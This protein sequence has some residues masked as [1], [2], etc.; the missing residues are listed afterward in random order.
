MYFLLLCSNFNS[1]TSIR[2]VSEFKFP[3]VNCTKCHD[4]ES[5]DLVQILLCNIRKLFAFYTL[6]Y[7]A[8]KGEGRKKKKKFKKKRQHT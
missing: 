8:E 1:K 7:P 4:L 5:Q 2:S 3:T 6:A